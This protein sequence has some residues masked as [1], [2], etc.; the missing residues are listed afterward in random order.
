MGCPVP[1]VC[2]T[3]A[4]AALLA[5]PARAV[6]VARAA[7][8]GSGLPVTVKL[9]SG[10]RAGECDGVELARRLVERG[11][12][13]RDRAAP[14]SGERSPTAGA[15]T[16]RSW[17]SSCAPLDAPVI[18]SGGL[19]SAQAV[20]EAFEQTGA[21]AVMLARGVARQPLAV[22]AGARFTR[23]AAERARGPRGARLGDRVRDASTSAS[24]APRA[25]CGASTRGT[26][27]GWRWSAPARASL[28]RERAERRLLRRECANCST[29]ACVAQPA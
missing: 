15:P 2:R 6:A 22:R 12:R 14:A 4:G 1:K 27:S 25:T 11:G 13:R 19:H 23:G 18:L 17:P 20:H 28:Q 3:G 9:R 5:D 16:T 8:E 10:W 29:C 21:A 24:R 7:A 26:S